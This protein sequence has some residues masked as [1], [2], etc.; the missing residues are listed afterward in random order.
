MPEAPGECVS[1]LLRREASLTLYAY[2]V[3]SVHIHYEYNRAIA[4]GIG[5]NQR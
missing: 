5:L 3:S 1:F 2:N 4:F